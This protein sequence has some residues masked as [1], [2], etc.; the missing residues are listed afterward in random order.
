MQTLFCKFH[1]IIMIIMVLYASAVVNFP[2]FFH[3]SFALE[4]QFSEYDNSLSAHS[5]FF[6]ISFEE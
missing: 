4:Y 3:F 2:F 5:I 6:V 1:I